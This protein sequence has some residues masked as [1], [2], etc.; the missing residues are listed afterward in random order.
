[1][2]ILLLPSLLPGWAAAGQVIEGSFCAAAS[3]SFSI[4]FTYFFI[5]PRLTHPVGLAAVRMM[6]AM[7]N[8]SWSPAGILSLLLAL[9]AMLSSG[10]IG[11]PHDPVPAG[12][13]S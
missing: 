2:V 3:T 4:L 9:F 7:A 6:L 12:G 8:R 1:M 11:A 10:S 5:P 13:N